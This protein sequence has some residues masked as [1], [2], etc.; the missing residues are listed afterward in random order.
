MLL[1]PCRAA[2]LSSCES[3]GAVL[4]ASSTTAALAQTSCISNYLLDFLA[5]HSKLHCFGRMPSAATTSI[6]RN[7][8]FANRFGILLGVHIHAIAVNT[9]HAQ[10]VYRPPSLPPM[11]SPR[12]DDC[13]TEEELL[14]WQQTVMSRAQAL[15]GYTSPD[16][17]LPLLEV[18]STAD[19]AATAT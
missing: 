5:R 4:L 16:V 9:W 11:V 12:P 7:S 18:S 15:T 10:E 13:R 8:S 2:L 6:S 14:V 17:L 19:S 1:W 3:L